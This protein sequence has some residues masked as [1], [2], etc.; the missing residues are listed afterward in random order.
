MHFCIRTCIDILKKK[1]IFFIL[2]ADLIYNICIFSC[3][4][5]HLILT[6]FKALKQPQTTIKHIRGR[7]D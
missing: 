7:L 6:N 2:L 3:F 5:Y 4:V 1:K